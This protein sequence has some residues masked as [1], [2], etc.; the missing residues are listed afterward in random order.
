[1]H[2]IKISVASFLWVLISC[3]TTTKTVDSI[4]KEEIIME[5]KNMLAEGFLAGQISFSKKEGDCPI[6][7]KIEGK[8]GVYYYDPIN[9]TEEYKKEDEKIWFKFAGLRR[10]NRCNKASPVNITEIQKR[11]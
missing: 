1:M 3:N 9:L 7:I 2:L 8:N 6:T 11:N 5:E 10:M 4:S